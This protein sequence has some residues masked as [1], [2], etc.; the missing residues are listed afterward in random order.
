MLTLAELVERSRQP[1]AESQTRSSPELLPQNLDE[2]GVQGDGPQDDAQSQFS[3]RSTPFIEEDALTQRSSSPA[4]SVFSVSTS[5][6]VTRKRPAEDYSDFVKQLS[7]E[8]RLKKEDSSKL[9]A[10]SQRSEQE[11]HLALY[12]EILS[13]KEKLSN[14]APAEAK[15]S[16]TDTAKTSLDNLCFKALIDPSAAA[17]VA[18]PQVPDGVKAQFVSELSDD[19][20]NNSAYLNAAL[21]R[22]HE[23]LSNQRC[24]I[25]AAIF[26]SIFTKSEDDSA[27]TMRDK[28]LDILALTKKVLKIRKPARAV[29]TIDHCV[30]MAFLRHS[31]V[32]ASKSPKALQDWW[33]YVDSELKSLREEHGEGQGLSKVFVAI[34][35]QDYEHFGKVDLTDLDD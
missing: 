15:I 21:T 30:R 28:P 27:K 24:S 31:A 26:G 6:S 29:V 5:A 9:L 17:Y 22:I 19:V 23:Q 32:M 4:P 2:D 35:E 12:A 33:R 7:R 11:R 10:Q 1:R 8:K 34:L 13:L 18:S 16:L 20:K 14:I 25:K 3:S